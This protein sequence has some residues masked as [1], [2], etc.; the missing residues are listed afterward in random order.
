MN[1][2]EQKARVYY[3]DELAG[4][5]SKT[6]DGYEFTYEDNYFFN[7]SKPGIAITFPKNQKEFRS[8]Y[9][10]PFFFGL[11][12]EGSN[13]ELQCRTLKIDEKDYFTRLIKTAGSD[14]IGAVT[15]KEEK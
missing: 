2:I 1:L 8:K 6:R 14:T 11:L 3:N 12:S 7:K 4:Y 9:L 15:V 5:L 13:K 10:F